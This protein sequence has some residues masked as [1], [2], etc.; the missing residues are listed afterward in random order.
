[1]QGTKGSI[2]LSE[3][4]VEKIHTRLVR[5]PWKMYVFPIEDGDCDMP[6]FV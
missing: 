3:K 5:N 6:M 4:I 2:H 1:M